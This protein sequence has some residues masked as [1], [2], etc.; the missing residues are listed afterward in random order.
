MISGAMLSRL[1]CKTSVAWADTA[2]ACE[3]ADIPVIGVRCYEHATRPL[4]IKG[5]KSGQPLPARHLLQRNDFPAT[6]VEQKTARFL[7]QSSG[8]IFRR[9]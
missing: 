9:G 3:A 6:E 8:K 2:K 7:L 5:T 1:V 4:E